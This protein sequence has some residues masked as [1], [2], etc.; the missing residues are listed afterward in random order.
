MT[1]IRQSGCLRRFWICDIW[2]QVIIF[3]T[4]SADLTVILI[5]SDMM[6]TVINFRMC[7]KFYRNIMCNI[8][9]NQ[10]CSLLNWGWFVISQQ[11]QV[12]RKSGIWFQRLF[13]A[14]YFFLTGSS[15]QEHGFWVLRMKLTLK[16]RSNVEG[17]FLLK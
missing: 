5:L 4:R 16:M 1:K 7:L 3:S 15:F 8:L 17:G 14:H 6:Q 2:D 9:T 11:G 13:Q 10:V 12:K